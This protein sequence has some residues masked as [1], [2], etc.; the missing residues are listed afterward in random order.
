[1]QNNKLHY[2]FSQFLSEFK[3]QIAE[4]V[5]T[6][7]IQVLGKQLELNKSRSQDDVYLTSDEV[8]SL[9]KISKSQLVKLRKKYKDFPVV[10]IESTVRFKKGELENFF[11]NLKNKKH[12]KSKR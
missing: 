1:M 11:Q 7:V 10:K 2:H 6:S 12:G 9:F 4:E 8:A 3:A 5:A